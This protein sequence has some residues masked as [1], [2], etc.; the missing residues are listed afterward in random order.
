MVKSMGQKGWVGAP[1]LPL[2]SCE[3]LSKHPTLKA[4]CLNRYNTMSYLRI[5]LLVFCMR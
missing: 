4:Y 1:V 3:A 5:G 2:R